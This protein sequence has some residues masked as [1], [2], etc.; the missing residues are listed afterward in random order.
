MAMDPRFN[1]VKQE[2]ASGCGPACVA[3][4][5]GVTYDQARQA[6]W[7]D[8]TRKLYSEYHELRPTLLKLKAK[9]APRAVRSTSLVRVAEPSIVACKWRERKV[10]EPVWHWIV[11]DPCTGHIYDPLKRLPLLLTESRDERYAPFSRLA[12]RPSRR[13]LNR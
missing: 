8:R 9:P 2:H 13:A 10:G 5:T 3:I 11:Y 6:M 1:H 7:G 12:V 4:F